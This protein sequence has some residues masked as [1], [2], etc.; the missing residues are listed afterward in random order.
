MRGGAQ[1]YLRS[2]SVALEV[3][4]VMYFYGHYKLA[5]FGCYDSS[6]IDELGYGFF[7]LDYPVK[8]C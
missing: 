3:K 4:T 7:S 6:F 1:T 8:I 5:L 2:A